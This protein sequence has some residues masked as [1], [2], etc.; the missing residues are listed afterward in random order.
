MCHRFVTMRLVCYVSKGVLALSRS[1]NTVK[2][3]E[4][5]AKSFGQTFLRRFIF[6]KG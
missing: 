2:G 4:M 1:T 6:K 5:L 3:K